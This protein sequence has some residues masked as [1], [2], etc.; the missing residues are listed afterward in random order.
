VAKCV[1]ASLLGGDDPAGDAFRPDR[2]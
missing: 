1:A 2:F